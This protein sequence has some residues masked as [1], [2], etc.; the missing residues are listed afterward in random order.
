MR[1]ANLLLRF[2]L[3]LSALS[4]LGY[5]GWRLGGGTL[6]R[7]LLSAGAVGVATAAWM[8]WVAPGSSADVAPVVRWTVEI[9]VFAAAVVALVGG[10]RSRPAILLAVA[11]AVNRAL[12]AAWD[13]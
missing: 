11:Y 4:A 1:A 3:E 10:G 6:T 9:A 12:M 2:L 8:L 5:G 7:L 13:Q